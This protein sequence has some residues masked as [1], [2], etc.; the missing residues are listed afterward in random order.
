VI[1]PGHIRAGRSPAMARTAPAR[2]PTVDRLLKHGLARLF[3]STLA[4][5][6]CSAVAMPSGHAAAHVTDGCQATRP[7]VAHYANGQ[8]VTDTR[9][10]IPCAT[11][12]HYTGETT[13][14]VTANGAVW[15]SASDWEWALVRSKD[16]GSHWDRR[17]HVV[18]RFRAVEVQHRCRRL[19]LG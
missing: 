3:V 10:L 8:I 16:N 7:A 1:G 13:I 17:R 19:P 5:G 14:G 6:L 18:Q 2:G 9:R 15:F 11:E 4:A 12:G